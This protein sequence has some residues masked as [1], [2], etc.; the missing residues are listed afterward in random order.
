MRTIF[1]IELWTEK[2]L[3]L[4]VKEMVA[5]NRSEMFVK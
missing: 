3:D 2:I 4:A 5:F 1:N